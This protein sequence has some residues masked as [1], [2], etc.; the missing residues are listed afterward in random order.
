[1]NEPVI[2][3]ALA[4]FP[5]VILAF[6]VYRKDKFD[7]EP[8]GMLIK[9]FCFGCLSAVPAIFLEGFLGS[10]YTAFGGN[11]MP[12]IV[13]GIYNGYIVAGFS[14]ELCKLLLLMMAVWR[15]RHFNEYFDGIVYA[16][17]VSL[18]FAG[19]EN[20][21]YVFQQDTFSNAIMTGSVRAL[22]SVP[23]HFL[24]GV[25]MGYYLALAKFQPERRRSYLFKALLYPMLLHG[26][27]DALL[28]IPEAMGEESAW[29]S[30]ILFPLFI[31][32]DI[33]M[34]KAGIRKLRALQEMSEQQAYDT[35]NDHDSQDRYDD[36]YNHYNDYGNGNDAGN[37]T[38]SGF[39]W[40]V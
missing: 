28:M 17:F 35:P 22:L 8:L 12:G 31:Y 19:L 21:L 18:G 20:I 32:F 23:G 4:I 14:E 10:L 2:M 27:F 9:A 33:R 11:A 5:V 40:D 26:T 15:S 1:M 30:A 39:R 16:T 36:S 6:Y 38:F 13:D 29:T 37:D 34:W 25:A 7:K 3:L 24:F